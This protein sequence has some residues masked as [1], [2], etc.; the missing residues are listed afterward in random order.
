MTLA[1]SGAVAPASARAE[2]EV[3][4]ALIS[5]AGAAEVRGTKLALFDARD[6]RRLFSF[7][8]RGAAQLLLDG[9]AIEARGAGSARS[10]RYGTAKSLIVE[11]EGAVEVGDG[12]YFGRLEVKP[13]KRG[14]LFVMNRL[15]L[16]TY[17]LGIVGSEMPPSWP[18]EALRAQAVAARTFAMQ[19]LMM[20][21]SADQPHDLEATVISQVYEGAERIQ[22]SVV[23]AVRS[24]RGE[25]LAHDRMLVESLFHSTCGGRTVASKDYFGGE[26]AYLVARDCTYCQG[27]KLY[28]WQTR[29]P[30]ADLSKILGQ[31]GLSRG[32]IASLRRGAEKGPIV[33]KDG[34]GSRRIDPKKLRRALGW[35]RLYSERFTAH[36]D[37]DMVV[38]AGR[39]FG[40][41][42]GMC[43]WGARGLADK[44]RNYREILRHYYTGS[45]VQRVY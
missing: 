15:P 38:F 40:H 29:M 43:Q 27:S 45:R 19:R 34:R 28:R 35:N 18:I 23:E 7:R 31:A 5:G 41:G 25:V 42:V 21:R 37:G 10:K 33:M 11:A 3:R 4:I 12:I 36:T 24:T 6:G 2:D 32:K 9:D 8:G 22:D 20:A 14:G 39:G 17:L 16:E 1:A 26:R 13:A 44:G 30:R